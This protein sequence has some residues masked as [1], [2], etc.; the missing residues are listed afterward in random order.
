MVSGVHPCF[1]VSGDVKCRT[2][3]KFCSSTWEMGREPGGREDEVLDGILLGVCEYRNAGEENGMKVNGRSGFSLVEVTI[4]L[5]VLAVLAAILAPA[6]GRY[7]RQ[8]KIVRAREDVQ[9]LGCAI[10]MYITDTANSY[11][12]VDGAY[13]SPPD[14]GASRRQ[15]RCAQPGIRKPRGHVGFGRRHTGG[16][17]HSW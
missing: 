15:W 5:M 4:I 16:Q 8:A 6:V 13:G 7:V 11:F 10:W 12:M 2:S 14:D 17:R 9:A 1:W 3:Y